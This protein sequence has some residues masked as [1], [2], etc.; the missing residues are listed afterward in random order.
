MQKIGIILSNGI[1]E[2][3]VN[4]NNKLKQMELIKNK[5]LIEYTIDKFI[6]NKNFNKIIVVIQTEYHQLL[7]QKYHNKIKL[8]N[9][10]ISRHKSLIKAIE[11]INM[12]LKLENNDCILIHDGNRILIDNQIINNHLDNIKDTKIIGTYIQIENTIC[13]K[14]TLKN[15]NRN[16]FFSLQTPQ[17]FKYE[18]IKNIKNDFDINNKITDTIGLYINQYIPKIIYGKKL[19][20]KITTYED[21]ELAKL[22]IENNN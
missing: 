14:S 11:W 19:N 3:F 16:D 15:L 21:F 1:G 12:N 8:I 20:F 9:G 2:R 7:N 17:T 4:N 6:S 5:H 22:I 13:D 10:D 18:V